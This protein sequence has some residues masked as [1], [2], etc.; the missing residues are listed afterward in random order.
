MRIYQH[1]HRFECAFGLGAVITLALLIVEESLLVATFKLRY[2]K[3]FDVWVKW[4]VYAGTIV[5][6][7]FQSNLEGSEVERHV[8]LGGGCAKKNIFLIFSH[9]EKCFLSDLIE[10]A[11]SD[12]FS[13]TSRPCP[14]P[15]PGSN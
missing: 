10:N 3:R 9:F 14:C 12:R 2:F 8:I 7:V 15:S 6:F 13:S 11:S 5:G 1:Y 4:A